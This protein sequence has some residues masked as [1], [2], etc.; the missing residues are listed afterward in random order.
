MLRLRRAAE[1]WSSSLHT[2]RSQHRLP[3]ARFTSPGGS[4]YAGSPDAPPDVHSI[5]RPTYAPGPADARAGIRD[6]L[7]SDGRD[8]RRNLPGQDWS[9]GAPVERHLQ[10]PRGQGCERR[11]DATNTR[12]RT[13]AGGNVRRPRAAVRWLLPE[14]EGKERLLRVVRRLIQSETYRSTNGG[15]SL[16]RLLERKFQIVVRVLDR[17]LTLPLVRLPEPSAFLARSAASRPS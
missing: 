2:V 4:G 11:Q 14:L 6:S 17:G 12:R 5:H 16:R 9:Y 10:D 3:R 7:L 1:G 8:Q 15:Q 13:V